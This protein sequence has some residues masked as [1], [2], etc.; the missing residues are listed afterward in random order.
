[1]GSR[2]VPVYRPYRRGCAARVDRRGPEQ[3]DRCLRGHHR[4]GYA[5]VGDA[6]SEFEQIADALDKSAQAYADTDT[7]ASV[8]LKNIYGACPGA[9]V[10]WWKHTDW[11]R[12]AQPVCWDRRSW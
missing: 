11:I 10:P 7:R 9:V 4:D 3:A 12:C 1:M 2:A 8:D 5:G 6:T